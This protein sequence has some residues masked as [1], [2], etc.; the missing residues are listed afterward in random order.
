MKIIRIKD[1]LE[2]SGLSRSSMYLLIKTGDFPQQVSL[3]ARSVGWVDYEI[4]DWVNNKIQLR[5]MKGNS[6][7]C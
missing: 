4:H 6:S 3:G 2:I 1:T 5:N 7:L